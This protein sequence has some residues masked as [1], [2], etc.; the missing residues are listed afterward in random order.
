MKKVKIALLGGAAC[1]AMAL[2]LFATS[3]PVAAAGLNSTANPALDTCA[4]P[5]L[6]CITIV[7]GAGPGGGQ[8]AMSDSA[9][10]ASLTEAEL[11]DRYAAEFIIAADLL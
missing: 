11:Y 6:D 7:I 9:T 5:T 1:A 2:G 8:T 3:T 4:P 10:I